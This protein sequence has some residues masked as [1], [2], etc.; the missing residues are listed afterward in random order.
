MPG[1]ASGPHIFS[2]HSFA[3]SPIHLLNHR[4]LF[5]AIILLTL[6]AAGTYAYLGGTH[7][8]STVR[9]VGLLADFLIRRAGQPP[10]QV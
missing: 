4:Y 2:I 8:G 9:P 10:S 1:Q 7:K 3:H 6:I 5:L